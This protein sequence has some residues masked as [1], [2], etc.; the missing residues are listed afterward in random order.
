MTR[1]RLYS[2]RMRPTTV[3]PSAVPPHRSHGWA[4]VAAA[5][6]VLG[7]C[8]KAN[9]AAFE[10]TITMRTTAAAHPQPREMVV[11]VKGDK[12]RFDIA[13]EGNASHAVYSPSDNKV[14][15]FLDTDKK[16]MD[17]DFSPPTTAPSTSPDS[18]G[19]TKS[20]THKKVA[21]LD[22]EQWTVKDASGKRSEVCIA[23]GIAF[24][25]VSSLRASHKPET[26]LAKEFREHKSFPLESIDYDASGTELTRMEVTAIDR[27][28]LDDAVFGVPE[29]YAKVDVPGRR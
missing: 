28:K 18:G 1:E 7:G 13:N 19:I 26:A 8:S 15:F 3:L 11:E 16:Y 5:A 17:M 23:Q 27:K 12:L 14:L 4:I 22:C 2:P 6:V 10:G 29:G 20:G 9:L 25:D 21:G 24:F